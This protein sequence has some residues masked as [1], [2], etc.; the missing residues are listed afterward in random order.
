MSLTSSD[1]GASALLADSPREQEMAVE[2][3]ACE[4]AAPSRPPC[5]AYAELLEVMDYAL[6]RLQLPW[7]RV[8]E[9]TAR[10]WLDERF[11]SGHNPVTPVSLPFLPDLHVEIE[12][13]LKHPYSDRVI[14]LI[15]R[16]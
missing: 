9:E 16:N 14:S 2:E 15:C 13:A 5:P 3:E 6:G 1:P 12:R 11:L 7:G 8:R 10:G 4:P